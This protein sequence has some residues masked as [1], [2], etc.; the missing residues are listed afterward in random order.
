MLLDLITE[1]LDELGVKHNPPKELS[2]E[3]GDPDSLPI[4]RMRIGTKDRR[5]IH[6]KGYVELEDFDFGNG[7]AGSFVCLNRDAVSFSELAWLSE[8]VYLPDVSR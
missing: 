5:K 2:G 4:L 3:H 8:S 7:A 1:A 6:M